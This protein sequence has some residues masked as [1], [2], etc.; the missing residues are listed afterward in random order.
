M[1]FGKAKDKVLPQS[2]ASHSSPFLD[3][4]QEWLERHG[5]YISAAVHW[6][7]VGAF[8]LLAA[9]LSLG[10]NL[11]QLQQIKVT[12]YVVEVD[13]LGN[14]TAVKPL[15][16]G[17]IIPKRL[18]QSDIVNMITNWRT[19][20]ADM[21]LQKRLVNKLAAYVGGSAHG[22]IQEWYGANNPFE[23][24]KSTLVSVD[25]PSLPLPVSSDS[26]RVSWLETIRNHQGN[27]MEVTAW[28]ATVAV[29]TVP[30]KDEAQIMAN[31]SG[32]IIT[33]LNFGKV[34]R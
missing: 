10:G 30:P 24:A 31:P 1:L 20:T 5:D 21:D 22:T 34:L 6:R 4:K 19:V 16:A 15:E 12:P 11:Y 8:A 13:K 33:S 7:M 25:V 14:A 27:T 9:I 28:E 32:V 17:G 2:P 29:I 18:I 26:W 23:R 3:A